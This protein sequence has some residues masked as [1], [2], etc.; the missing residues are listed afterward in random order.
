M[1]MLTVV[2]SLWETDTGSNHSFRHIGRLSPLRHTSS[3][4]LI[5]WSIIRSCMGAPSLPI[6]LFFH[7]WWIIISLKIIYLC[8]YLI[9]MIVVS[10]I[11]LVLCDVRTLIIMS[12][13]ILSFFLI[14]NDQYNINPWMFFAVPRGLR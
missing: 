7:V 6:Y 12:Y 4:R 10:W 5:S 13:D 3:F 8:N 2:W 11:I 14:Q 9:W 1:T